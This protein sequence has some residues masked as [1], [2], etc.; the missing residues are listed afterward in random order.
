MTTT[1][2]RYT[3]RYYPDKR[4]DPNARRNSFDTNNPSRYPERPRY[5][6]SVKTTTQQPTTSHKTTHHS[7]HHQKPDT[8][9][10]SYD[11]VTIIRGEIFIFKGRYLWR[12]GND[13]L[14]D[15]YPHEINKMWNELPRT[16]THVDSV[17]EN[18][19][20]QI[21]FFIGET[22]SGA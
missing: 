1:T 5:Y 4:Y 22:S 6:P 20:R 19:R 11:A 12:I 13:G 14:F 3:Q 10:T 7:K 2:R 18:K 21:V 16:L 8:C 17:Y 15:G 9:N